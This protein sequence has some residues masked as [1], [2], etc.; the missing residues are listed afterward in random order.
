[1]RAL[2]LAVGAALF[3]AAP[4]QAEVTSSDITTPADATFP[5]DDETG[6]HVTVSGTATI[7][8]TD[9][10]VDI[11][12]T[13]AHEGSPDNIGG[14]SS[15]PVSD[16]DGSFSANVPLQSINQFPCRLRAVPAGTIPGD[17]T[18]FTGPRV[19]VGERHLHTVTG[20]WGNYSLAMTPLSGAT[21]LEDPS[22]CGSE[23]IYA[24]DPATLDHTL[25]WGCGD[26]LEKQDYAAP[27]TRSHV[28]VDGKNAYFTNTFADLGDLSYPTDPLPTITYD[29]STG[30]GSVSSRQTLA[31]CT[32]GGGFPTNSTN[33]SGFAPAGVRVDHTGGTLEDGKLTT[34]SDKFV[35]VD[36]HAHDL[37]LLVGNGSGWAD[38]SF[39][40]PGQSS[41][42]AHTTGDVLS[43]FPAGPGA[44]LLD[45]NG[46]TSFGVLAWSGPA[47][48]VR[49]ADA[50]NFETRYLVHVPAC[51]VAEIR[52][53]WGAGFTMGDVNALTPAA[54]AA[55]NAPPPTAPPCGGGASGG[56]PSSPPP[57]GPTKLLAKLGKVT[58]GK[59][60]TVTVAVNAP[61]AGGLSAV[62][63][64]TVPRAAK[65]R[66][67]KL[68][69][70][71]ARKSITKAGK[72]KLVLKLNKK[73]RKLF[74]AKHR[75]R[76][77]V[78]VSYKP[79]AAIG[80]KLT[81]RLT[82]KRRGR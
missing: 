77:T 69:V 19:G 2:L 82:L 34:T 36:G 76:V 73:G 72:V 65:K 1:M 6:G 26:S 60:G 5:L 59:N 3:M 80:N 66:T 30:L 13:Y 57:A 29:S 10:Q 9:E 14:V 4:A 18:P 16:V 32:P 78:A 12:C 56:Q 28:Q 67:K 50:D 58:A 20:G 47:N 17:L 53:A 70:S 33:C 31:F 48:D 24:M 38:S 63:T 61:A 75:L 22:F 55:V 40:F 39:K 71:R 79:T 25:V 41:F 43:G 49:F 81:K 54:L 44:T 62:E 35:S 64:T 11:T 74:R 23:G 51:G 46:H 52:F 45:Q 27:P 21:V 42:A 68:T 8:S 7:T 15:V 37:D